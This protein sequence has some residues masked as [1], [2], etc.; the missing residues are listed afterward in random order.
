MTSVRG[1]IFSNLWQNQ[2]K[3]VV[4]ILEVFVNEK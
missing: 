4:A 1:K 2:E 3:K